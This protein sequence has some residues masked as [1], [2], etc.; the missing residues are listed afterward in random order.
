MLPSLTILSQLKSAGREAAYYGALLTDCPH[1]TADLKAAWERGWHL[2]RQDRAEDIQDGRHPDQH[3]VT[4]RKR[5]H[6]ASRAS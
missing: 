1:Q 6:A 4:K 2:G 5:N 3:T